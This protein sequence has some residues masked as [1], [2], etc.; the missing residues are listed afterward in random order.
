MTE[1]TH[2][3][4]N[5]G[6]QQA[7]DP[8]TLTATTLSAAIDLQNV[9]DAAVA[10]LVGESG[11]TLS[12]SVYWELEL[13][14]SDDDSTYTA[15]ADADI[16]NAIS[17][18]TATGTFALIDA[19][20]EDDAV[21]FTGYKGNKRYLKVNIRATGTHTNGT[22]MGVLGLKGKQAVNPVN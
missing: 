6:F 17:G 8:A 20:A 11:D 13:Q 5:T 9:G 15:V 3:Y 19:A 18:A 21:Y 2:L 22:P 10:V 12:G 7:V 16:T 1:R 14:E 4:F